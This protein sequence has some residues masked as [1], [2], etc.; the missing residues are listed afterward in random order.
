MALCSTMEI[1]LTAVRS[2]I[3]QKVWWVGGIYRYKK[4]FGGRVVYP[5]GE[6]VGGSLSCHVRPLGKNLDYKWTCL[7]DTAVA[8]GVCVRLPEFPGLLAASARHLSELFATELV[9]DPLSLLDH[10]SRAWV[11]PM[12][13]TLGRR[14]LIRDFESSTLTD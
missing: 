2:F 3:L 14:F 1:L 7:Q 10:E 13:A 11:E 12:L 4:L 9:A 5:D 8:A 6:S